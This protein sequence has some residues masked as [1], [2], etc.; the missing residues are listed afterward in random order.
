MEDSVEWGIGGVVFSVDH[1]PTLKKTDFRKEI[2][3]ASIGTFLFSIIVVITVIFSNYWTVV[4]LALDDTDGPEFGYRLDVEPELYE[5]LGAN[6]YPYSS[7]TEY[8]SFSSTVYIWGSCISDC[9]QTPSAWAGSGVIISSRWILTAAHVV[10]DMDPNDSFIV[11][12]P[13]WEYGDVYE[14]ESFYIH[15]SW[16]GVNELDLGFDIAL[17][18]LSDYIS[19]VY[20]SSWANQE[21]IDES[22]VDATIFISGFGDYSDYEDSFCDSACLTDGDEFYSQRRAWANTLDRVIEIGTQSGENDV[23]SL[24]GGHIVYDFDSPDG[25][26]N[27]LASGNLGFNFFQDY[28]YAG[29]GDS[30]PNPHALEG[31]AVP[32]DSGGPVFAKIDGKWTVIGLTSH[33]S[34][35]SGY[36]DVEFNT[37][38]SVHSE[39]ICLISTPSRPISGC[40]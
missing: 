26:S 6:R 38:V 21:D 25:R 32:G 20:P 39:W 28:S 17:V 37:R 19:G 29:E 34:I 1:E 14:V 33:G 27:S 12:G 2:V 16:N 40:A 7:G 36:G 30:S 5:D 23:V 11:I 9:P 24:R 15:P 3:F 13:D 18:A 4:S 31:T 22:L 35:A 10:E 8:P